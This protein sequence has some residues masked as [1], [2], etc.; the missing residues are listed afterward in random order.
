MESRALYWHFPAYLE[1]YDGLQDE[2][3]DP[4]F[5]TRPVSVIRKGDWKLLMFHEEWVLDGGE[6]KMNTNNAIE[7]Y[8]L[9]NDLG[10]SKNLAD[11]NTGKRDELLEQLIHWQN[12][13][14]APIPTRANP[15]YLEK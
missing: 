10:E 7:L 2:S 9:K 4:T 13:I 11:T 14:N 6:E 5:R 12:E 3:R 1:A 15:E 8:N